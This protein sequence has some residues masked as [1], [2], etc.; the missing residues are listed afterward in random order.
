MSAPQ[1]EPGTQDDPAR[2]QCE[3]CDGDGHRDPRRV[4]WGVF[5]GSERDSDGQPTHLRVMR[6][7]G[8]HVAQSDADWLWQ[9][10]RSSS[11]LRARV[12]ELEQRNTRLGLLRVDAE[13]GVDRV[14]ALHGVKVTVPGDEE[15]GQCLHCAGDWPCATRRALDGES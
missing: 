12:A 7:N 5:V 8:S 9:V 3:H 13:A 4:P 1:I 14:R 2:A 10:I 6:S 15:F 11:E